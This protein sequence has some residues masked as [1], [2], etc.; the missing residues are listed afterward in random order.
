MRV[1]VERKSGQRMV[2]AIELALAEEFHTGQVSL[3]E[4]RR[5]VVFH[6]MEGVR[7]TAPL[8]REAEQG[9]KAFTLDFTTVG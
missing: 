7:Y 6:D 2:Q 1:R 3:D 5:I 9:A 8:P 4:D